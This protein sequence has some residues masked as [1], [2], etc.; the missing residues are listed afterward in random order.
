M[1]TTCFDD[2]DPGVI[3]LAD[4]PIVREVS[5]DWRSRITFAADG[6]VVENVIL[7][8]RVGGA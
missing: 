8:A 5:R 4:K 7:E 3:R 2:D 1:R 6:L